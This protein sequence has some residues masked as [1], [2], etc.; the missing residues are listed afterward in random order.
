MWFKKIEDIPFNIPEW[1]WEMRSM[2]GIYLGK[3]EGD[4]REVLTWRCEQLEQDG[5]I[6]MR[7]GNDFSLRCMNL[8]EDWKCANTLDWVGNTQDC[9]IAK[10]LNVIGDFSSNNKEAA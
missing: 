4:W 8:L 5:I 10:L 7:D 1:V 6:L 9:Q 3:G 2:E